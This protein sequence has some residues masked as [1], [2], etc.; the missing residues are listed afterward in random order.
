[1]QAV[2]LTPPTHRWQCPSCRGVDTSR[3][4]RPHTRFHSCPAHNMMTTPF[5]L[6][7]PGQ[8]ELPVAQV[9]HVEI[10]REDYIGDENAGRIMALRT[11][12][13]DGSYDCT[14]YAPSATLATGGAYRHEG[15]TR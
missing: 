6:L 1:M 12:R 11:E 7:A 3:E 10:E 8:T 5:V 14:V 13:A 4:V 9:R 15:E 2:L